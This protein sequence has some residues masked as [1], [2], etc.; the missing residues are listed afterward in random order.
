MVKDVRNVDRTL[1]GVRPAYFR[2]IEWLG[3]RQYKFRAFLS[4]AACKIGLFMYRHIRK[5][6]DHAERDN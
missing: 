2:P 5:N 1:H 3:G 4:G 6:L